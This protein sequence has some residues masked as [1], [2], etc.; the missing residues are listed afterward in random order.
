M[1]DAFVKW[2]TADYEVFQILFIRSVIIMLFSFLKLSAEGNL[3]QLKT[4]R[5]LGHGI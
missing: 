4:N 1:H 3:R 2:L 5:P